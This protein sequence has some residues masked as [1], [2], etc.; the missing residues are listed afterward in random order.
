MEEEQL[1]DAITDDIAK[2]LE[3]KQV[4]EILQIRIKEITCLYEIRRCMGLELSGE[5]VCRNI[6]KQLIPAMQ[7]PE[8]ATVAIEIGD[9]NILLRMLARIMPM[10]MNC[11]RTLIVRYVKTAIGMAPP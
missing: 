11:V 1:I 2:W 9:K 6:I 4:D 10:C 8:I 3:H 7:F 5:I